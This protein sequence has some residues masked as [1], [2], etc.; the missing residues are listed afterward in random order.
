VSEPGSTPAGYIGRRM[1]QVISTW[2]S[3]NLATEAFREFATGKWM[4]ES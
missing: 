4:L 2:Y 3:K 1:M